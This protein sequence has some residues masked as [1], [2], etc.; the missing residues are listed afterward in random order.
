M[1]FIIKNIFIRVFFKLIVLSHVCYL[2]SIENIFWMNSGVHID[3]LLKQLY[4][5]KYDTLNSKLK[6]MNIDEK[7]NNDVSNVCS[8]KNCLN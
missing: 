3:L 5:L 2:V 4:H 1:E 6:K 8:N 7:L